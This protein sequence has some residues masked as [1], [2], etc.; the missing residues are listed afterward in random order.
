MIYWSQSLIIG[1]FTFIKILRLKKFNKKE[2]KAP[3]ALNKIGVGISFL[4]HYGIFHLGY[5]FFATVLSQVTVETTYNLINILLPI[6]VFFV[7]HLF[8]FIYNLRNGSNADSCQPL[9]DTDT[10]P[11]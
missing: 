3:K 10:L 4:I 1:F 2:L 5:L 6:S 9:W 8:S 11:G 7:N